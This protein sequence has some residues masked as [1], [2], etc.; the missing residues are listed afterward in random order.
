MDLGFDPEKFL[1]AQPRVSLADRS[2]VQAAAWLESAVARVRLL[3]DV[4]GSA[5]TLLP[6]VGSPIMPVILEHDGHPFDALEH[7]TSADYFS[8]LGVTL[9]RGRLFTADEVREQAAV[10]VISQSLA[11]AVWGAADPIGLPLSNAD[12]G[13]N[14]AAHA[15][16]GVP[17]LARYRVIGIVNDVVSG[18]LTLPGARALYLPMLRDDLHGAARLLVRTRGDARESLGRISQ[19][20]AAVDPGVRTYWYATADDYAHELGPARMAATLTSILGAFAI[21]LAVLGL[22][23][24][25]SVVVA[26]RTTEVGIRMALGATGAR[27]VGQFVRESLRP[28]VVGLGVGLVVALIGSRFLASVLYGISPHDPIAVVSAVALLIVSAVLAAVV[29][30]RRAAHLDPA[31]VL[32][33]TQ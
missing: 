7:R 16:S 30:A 1:T 5:L 32:R 3:P 13:A 24:V 33:A 29:P 9:A 8:V 15:P 6:P 25:T 18:R 19:A 2:G 11:S 14:E 21:A 20:L 10:A 12:R 26:Q 4:A 22:F 27:I 28:V 23:G 17:D 31:S